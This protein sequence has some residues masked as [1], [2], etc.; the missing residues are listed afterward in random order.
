[1]RREHL[2]RDD[3][4]FTMPRAEFFDRLGLFAIPAFLEP[5]QCRSVRGEL[6]VSTETFATVGKGDAIDLDTRR[7]RCRKASRAAR[8]HVAAKLEGVRAAIGRHFRLAVAGFERAQFL[9][10][11]PGDFFRPH[12]DGNYDLD[13]PEVLR[14]RKVSVVVFLNAPGDPD[15][16]GAYGGGSLMFYGLLRDPRC[17]SVGFGLDAEEG[18]LIAFR[19]DLLHEVTPV[20]HG[21]RYTIVS[22]HH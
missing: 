13:A 3:G 15:T 8:S 4:E 5:A 22:W 16:S 9:C 1:V 14:E 7:L 20:T 6:A 12:R 2:D 10:Y 19:S 18:L 11:K 17:Q 21:E